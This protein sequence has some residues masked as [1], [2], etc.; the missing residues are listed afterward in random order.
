MTKP[1]DLD[2]LIRTLARIL[3]GERIEVTTAEVR[4][5]LAQRS[6]AAEPLTSRL[7]GQKSL[8]PI[9]RAFVVKLRERVVEM[10]AAL[11]QADWLQ[12]ASLAHW[13]KGSAGSMGYDAF[14]DPALRLEQAAKAGEG[15]QAKQVFDEVRALAERVVAPEDKIAAA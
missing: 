6:T 4:A 13:L 5:P 10:E 8:L 3:G 7:A 1:I 15:S 12:V 9:L 11:Q 14:T 2:A